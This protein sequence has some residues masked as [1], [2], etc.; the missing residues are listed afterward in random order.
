MMLLSILMLLPMEVGAADGPTMEERLRG[1]TSTALAKAARRQ[2]DP[3]RGAVLFYRDHITCA[4]CHVGSDAAPPIGPDLSRLGREY[5]DEMIVEAIL[6]PSKRIAESHASHRFA[7]RDGR[8]FTGMIVEEGG[9][10]VVIRDLATPT[11]DR[12]EFKTD[13]I[14]ER[15]VA[16]VS[17]MPTGL[18]NGLANRG[19]FL[20]L[21][22]YV[23]AI[24]DGG[25]KRAAELVPV[26]SKLAP[27]PLPAYERDL[28]HAGLIAASDDGSYSRGESIYLRVCSNCHGTKTQAGSMPTS[29]RFA[30]AELRNGFDPH[31]MY[32]TITHGFQQ[33]PAQVWMTPRQKYDVIHYIREEYFKRD[34]PARYREID[35]A[36]L[37]G[38]PKGKSRGPLADTIDPWS[39]MDYGN[40]VMTTIEVGGP[41]RNIA[42]K[43]LALRLDAGAGGVA[44]G[45]AFA[46]YDRETMRVAAFWTGRGFIDW[47]GI[48][49]DGRHGVHPRRVGRIEFETSE[50]PGWA[51]PVTGRFDDPRPLSRERRPYGPMPRTW[52]R[53]LGTYRHGDRSIVSYMV[54][55]TSILDSLEFHEADGRAVLGRVFEVGPSRVPLRVRI[56]SADAAVAVDG[57]ADARI[58][59]EGASK[60]IEL[61]PSTGTRVVRAWIASGT[62]PGLGR[63]AARRPPPESLASMTRGGPRRFA[64]TLESSV[65][66]EPTDGPFAVDILRSPTASPWRSQMRFTGLDFSPDGRSLVVCDW[67]GDVWR[68]EGIDAGTR[69]R[70]RRIASGLFQPLGLKI[71]DGAIYVGCRDQI[72]ILRDAN[73]DGETD[74]IEC[75]NDDHQ[76]TEHFHEFAMD[77]QTDAAG[78]FYY[79]KGARH[80]LKALVPHHGTLLRVSKDGS[81]TDILAT[82][83][84][85]PNG[86]AVNPDGTFYVTDQEGHW[87]PK[88]RINLVKTGRF[89]GNLWGFTDVVDPSDS[90]MEPPIC[91]ITNAFDR[92]PSQVV[93]VVPE[94]WGPLVGKRLVLSYGYGTIQLLLEQS[95]DGRLQG[96]L[97]SLPIP[98][99]PTGL[100]RARFHPR[101]GGLYAAGMFAWAGNQQ[102]PGGLYRIR[103]TDRPIEV[104]SGLRAESGA[105]RLD[106]TAEVDPASIR[107]EKVAIRTWGLRRSE[108]YGSPHLDEKPLEVA[109]VEA[110]SDGRSIRILAPGL[111]PTMGMEIRF[112]LRTRSGRPLVGTIHSTIH[113]LDSPQ[114]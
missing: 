85:A 72:A 99:A 94:S 37:A 45:R 29:P 60:T 27:P 5:A 111:R 96:G 9:G 76:V 51:D 40:A 78:N 14:E 7:L 23:R 24:A 32:R 44:A 16:P 33:M 66:T 95:V 61:P 46:L 4:K 8:T 34:N 58:G 53:Y 74:F 106:F 92:S 110:G 83:F 103:R 56:A 88:N 84:R 31:S 10:R 50:G 26:A 28:D 79:T 42:Y 6:E 114:P 112:E 30:S 102:Q 64:E 3:L 55:E 36:Y 25:P 113:A 68:V 104:V 101:D 2:G 109:G 41:K 67:D 75:F 63:F 19:E 52:M 71:V 93:E 90:A 13:Q 65:D 91:W 87:I 77:L 21:V 107:P 18:V 100:I 43:G 48:Q 39:S 81:R 97:V 98:Q 38:L 59:L 89:Y 57:D 105:I 11:Y 108:N 82:G 86:V 73:D 80:A 12:R 22:S 62:G 47:R 20:D 54:G 1:E 49:L 69:L 17:T 35:D 15:A 70:W